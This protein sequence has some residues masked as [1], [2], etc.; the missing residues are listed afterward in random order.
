MDT[1]D[2]DPIKPL[3]MSDLRIAV[4]AAAKAYGVQSFVIVGRASLAASLP[5]SNSELRA[6]MDIDLFPPWDE[7]KASAWA[8]ADVHLGRVSAFRKEHGFYV[9]RVAEWTTK[10]L[11]AT[12][13]ERAVSFSVEDINV[14]ALHLLDLIYAKLQA[15]RH[16]DMLFVRRAMEL[17]AASSDQLKAFVRLE[18]VDSKLLEKLLERLDAAAE[19]EEDEDE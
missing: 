4:I 10:L 15:G 17:G 19:A 6:T 9:E 12:W 5:D 2:Q 14:K 3:D 16:K 7:S 8:A 18:T 1:A 13:I 11:P